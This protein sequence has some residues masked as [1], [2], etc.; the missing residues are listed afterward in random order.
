MN[1]TTKSSNGNNGS[2]GNGNKHHESVNLWRETDYGKW[3]VADSCTSMSTSIQDFALP[4]IAQS[5]TGSAV[6]ATLLN[7]IMTACA[8]VFRLPGGYLQDRYDRKKLMVIFGMIGFVMFAGCSAMLALSPLGYAALIILALVLGTR[9]GLLGSTSNTMLRGLVPDAQLPKVMSMNYSRDSAIDL[10]GAPISS[11][12]MMIGNWVPMV[13]NALLNLLEAIASTRITRYWKP[14]HKHESTNGAAHESL[15]SRLRSFV[16]EATSGLKWLLT[17]PFQRR[18]LIAEMFCFPCFNAFMLIT[19]L[20]ANQS[21]TSQGLLLATV[22]NAS[23]SVSILIGS[24]IAN[25]MID[26]VNGGILVIVDMTMLSICTVTV[27]LV[28]NAIVKIAILTCALLL[29]PAGNAV[30]SGFCASIVS[31][32]NQGR[33]A[34]GETMLSLGISPIATLLA[35]VAMQHFGYRATAVTLG[36]LILL[37]ALPTLT[38]RP[39]RTLPKPDKWQEHLDNSPEI[40]RF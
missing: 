16:I 6:L 8:A 13:A 22:L 14:E 34:A 24:L 11:A 27:A 2:G 12:L 40:H 5:I 4:L 31:P 7:S 26:R 32:G 38:L 25:F 19:L 21:G 37:F 23:L 28:D 36:V 39:I 30:I 1:T 35:G 20:D 18:M 29:F 10:I 15:S 9:T 3:F 17:D 33:V